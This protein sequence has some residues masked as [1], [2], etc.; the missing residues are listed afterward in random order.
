MMRIEYLQ[1]PI[2]I[3]NVDNHN[4]L[5]PQILHSIEKM[6]VHSLIEPYNNQSISNTDWHLNKDFFR[7]YYND[8]NNLILQTAG[9]LKENLKL[10]CN[11]FLS[12]YWFQQYKNGDNHTWHNHESAYYSCV[13]YVELPEKALKTTFKVIDKEYEFDVSEGDVICFPSLIY[14]QSKKNLSNKT[15]TI[16]SFNLNSQW[17]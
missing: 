1:L 17:D 14:H 10:D 15:K 12:N 13:Y 5:K 6:G 3:Y 16:I 4:E 2:L 9:F 11:L 7:P 8:I